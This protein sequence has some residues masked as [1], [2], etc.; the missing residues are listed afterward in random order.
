MKKVSL[1]LI[2]I[3]L[4]TFFCTKSP[5]EKGIYAEFTTSRGFFVLKL[6]FEK[7]PLT[8]AN[9]IG[10]T[11]GTIKNNEKPEG[12]PFYKGNTMHINPGKWIHMGYSRNE[13]G[14]GYDFPDEFHPDL[15]HDGLG[16]VSSNNP[17]WNSNGS[18]FNIFL[19]PQPEQDNV[20]P[21]FGKII[22]GIDVIQKIQNL[23]VI[24]SINIVRVGK[25]AKKFKSDERSFRVLLNKALEK[26]NQKIEKT[27]A[28]EIQ[29]IKK[30][31]PD[32]KTT[33]SGL[34]YKIFKEGTG[35]R[36]KPGMMLSAKFIMTLVNG[37]L[38]GGNKNVTQQVVV[39]TQFMIKGW[40]EGMLDMKV[41]ER[42]LLVLPPHL[43]YGTKGSRP[44]GIHPGALFIIDIEILEILKQNK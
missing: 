28:V 33:K 29:E 32:I 22:K 44:S 38:V 37:K 12:Q 13:K 43:S 3:L 5:Y 24:N 6:E 31:Y 34:M 25:N 2:V 26:L 17:L 35:E 42:R 8:V 10:L 1:L 4:S 39:G 18:I 16:V 15:K 20:F 14:L 23:D 11:E 19:S 9:F 41:G 7:V 36:I 30:K 21:V 40:T 27:A